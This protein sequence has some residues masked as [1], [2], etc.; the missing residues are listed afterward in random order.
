MSRA[1]PCA[2]GMA[3]SCLA[4]RTADLG[5]QHPTASPSQ[6]LSA[7]SAFSKRCSLRSSDCYGVG[8]PMP[9]VERAVATRLGKPSACFLTSGTAANQASVRA[10]L[11]S[12]QRQS[13]ALHKTSHMVHLDCLHD[14]ATQFLE[15]NLTEQVS[16]HM[17]GIQCQ[18]LSDAP[19][20]LATFAG[21]QGAIASAGVGVVVLEIPQ[22]MSGG[23]SIPF[24]KL[25]QISVL[26][27]QER[28]HLH[29]DGARL[30]E[31][32]P[33]YL[34][35][36]HTMAEVCALFDS[37]YVSF[38][39]GLNAITGAPALHSSTH[40][41][42]SLAFSWAAS[43]WSSGETSVLPCGTLISSLLMGCT[44]AQAR[45]LPANPSLWPRRE[46]GRRH[47]GPYPSR[48]QPMHSHVNCSSIPTLAL[49]G[50]DESIK[51]IRTARIHLLGCMA[52]CVNCAQF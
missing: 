7:L 26:C 27:R 24:E 39:K 20:T 6:V 12:Q 47:L 11:Q 43:P 8:G 36:G 35:Q 50:V 48:T 19:H 22:R 32:S 13:V 34:S 1:A 42:P 46:S 23:R 52:G 44:S 2:Q 33:Y 18:F 30:W 29:M 25:Q 37:I 14:G 5:A 40:C 17:L 9:A 10:A 21:V 38:Y 31:A 3:D 49:R 51:T 28:V 15:A 45:A 41:A 4:S 16:A